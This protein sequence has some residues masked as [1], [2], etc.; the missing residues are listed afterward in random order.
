[1]TGSRRRARVVVVE[2]GRVALIKRVRDG[3]TYYIFPGGGIEDGETPE[4]AAVREAYEELGV[5]VRIVELLH[6]EEFA[7]A[8]FLYFR[9][10]IVGGEFGS[11]A[12]PDHADE[13]ELERERGGTHEPVW[14]PLTEL[15]NVQVG[16]DV[17][18]RELVMRLLA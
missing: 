6:E 9:A 12:W 10:E 7:G 8:R 14:L 4:Q 5:H 11:G 3:T 17:R 13:T 18:P 15:A 16:L 2:D 1:M